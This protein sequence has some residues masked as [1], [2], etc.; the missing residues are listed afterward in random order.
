MKNF[1]KN[2]N[3]YKINKKFLFDKLKPNLKNTTIIKLKTREY[4]DW[5][6]IA[7]LI[8]N[9]FRMKNSSQV[10]TSGQNYLGYLEFESGMT[11]EIDTER[12]DQIIRSYAGPND[13][14]LNNVNARVR[15]ISSSSREDRE[16]VLVE[17]NKGEVSGNKCS[18]F[19]NNKN[20]AGV[21]TCKLKTFIDQAQS[22]R[23]ISDEYGYIL[24]NLEKHHSAIEIIEIQGT[25]SSVKEPANTESLRVN[26]LIKL[27]K[28]Q[29]VLKN[30]LI[31]V[32]TQ[33]VKIIVL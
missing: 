8:A 17:F 14:I 19:N 10:Y 1:T 25:N 23:D 4:E 27:I 22:Q 18:I 20:L 33:N 16:K 21:M 28:E 26:K 29:Q 31:S 30:K 5:S 9:N 3:F 6:N 24:D 32:K 7:S 2:L 11:E 12:V 13:F 15:S